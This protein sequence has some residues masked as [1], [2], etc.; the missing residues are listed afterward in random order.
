MKLRFELTQ[1]LFESP[2]ASDLPSCPLALR[3]LTTAPCLIAY[4]G[5]GAIDL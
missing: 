2:I 1:G 5:P 3:P 4:T